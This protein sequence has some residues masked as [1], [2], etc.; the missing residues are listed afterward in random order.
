MLSEQHLVLFS[1]KTTQHL[2]HSSSH[3]LQKPLLDL[4]CAIP[5]YWS[6]RSSELTHRRAECTEPEREKKKDENKSWLKLYV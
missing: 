6:P 3:L 1:P 5:L 4:W 2:I